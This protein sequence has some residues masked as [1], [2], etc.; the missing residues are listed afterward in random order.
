M[1]SAVAPEGLASLGS[2]VT[3]GIVETAGAAGT[4]GSDALLASELAAYPTAGIAGSIPAA[5]TGLTTAELA[6]SEMAAYPTAG[7]AGTIPAEAA[8][9]VVVPATHGGYP[10]LAASEMAAYPTSGIVGT[11]PAAATG[12][13]EAELAASEMAAYPTSGIVGPIPPEAI[14]GT[15]LSSTTIPGTTSGIPDLSKV[16]L[17]GSGGSSS[18]SGSNG[19]GLLAL[20]ALL[21]SQ[22]K[23]GTDNSYQGTIPEYT[24]SRTQNAMPKKYRPGQ[25]G[26]SYF[27]PATY[28]K[29]AADGGLMGIF[30]VNRY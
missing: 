7:I 14:T 17:P 11:P 1:S 10:S 20:A 23:G 6:A 26:V 2:T 5:A 27:T 29:K 12:L 19:L 22:N 16:K 25:G 8:T 24:M 30:K 4:L 9:G 3:P 21:A 28:T 15:T 18:S 13:T